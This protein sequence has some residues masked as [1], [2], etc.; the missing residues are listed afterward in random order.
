MS[1]GM[2]QAEAL[3]E[4]ASAVAQVAIDGGA[5]IVIGMQRLGDGAVGHGLVERHPAEDAIHRARPMHVPAR[6]V[7][8]PDGAS[9]QGL[10]E[11]TGHVVLFPR[12]L[13]R[14][15]VPDAAAEEREHE[16][17]A[18]EQRNL[19]ARVTPPA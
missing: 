6:E 9:G 14:G 1:V 19:E 10:G 4:F 2:A 17:G 7:P 5:E 18:D 16:P 15:E 8:A 12:C 3:I 11:V 13:R